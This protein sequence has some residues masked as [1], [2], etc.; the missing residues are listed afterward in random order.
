M[1]G[2]LPIH[3]SPE[4]LCWF[5]LQKSG[6]V[7]LAPKA[8]GIRK[9]IIINGV[10]CDAEYIENLDLYLI[11]DVFNTSNKNAN[12]FERMNS[13]RKT[14]ST[15]KDLDLSN[16]L[17]NKISILENLIEKDRFILNEYLKQTTDEIKWYPKFNIIS[18]LDPNIFLECV[19]KQFDFGFPVDGWIMFPLSYEKTKRKRAIGKYKPKQ[20]MTI[21]VEFKNNRWRTKDGIEL[22]ILNIPNK[23]GVWRCYWNN[24][25]IANDYRIEKKD[26]NPYKLVKFL[27]DFHKCP[28]DST[29]LIPLCKVPYYNPSYSILSNGISNYLE[30]QRR[31]F[32]SLIG[33]CVTNQV[34]N[35]FDVGC[36]KGKII[37][38]LKVSF[39]HKLIKSF[40]VVGIDA[41]PA[42]IWEAKSRHSRFD[43]MWGDF[44]KKNW[45]IESFLKVDFE[46]NFDLI[47]SNF[48]ISY[49]L[50]NPKIFFDGI[51]KLTRIGSSFFLHFLDVEKIETYPFPDEIKIKKL[52]RQYY[53]FDYPWLNGK[54]KEYVLSKSNIIELF[55]LYDWFIND[56]I[57]TFGASTCLIFKKC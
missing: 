47:V 42:S 16:T 6:N 49:A 30:S 40:K 22:S 29:M 50:S 12:L 43:W 20:H 8:D 5:A 28:W 19:N 13:L 35:I 53:E 27:T 36:G 41:D 48:S 38:A 1:K 39:S 46:Q 51:N 11:F 24:G 23:E 37:Q 2:R 15:A 7:S 56:E 10:I 14:H 52:G 9:E 54:I 17:V 3:V 44:T 25:W 4:Q 33:K 45:E 55:R 26:S 18:K 57:R 32:Y 31:E 21:D 34:F